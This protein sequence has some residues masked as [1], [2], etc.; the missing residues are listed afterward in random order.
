MKDASSDRDAVQLLFGLIEKLKCFIPTFFLHGEGV[1]HPCL[2][3]V[4]AAHIDER[5]GV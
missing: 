3:R 1:V 5:V 4:L 2:S